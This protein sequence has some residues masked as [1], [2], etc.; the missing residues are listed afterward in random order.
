MKVEKFNPDWVSPKKPEFVVWIFLAVAK[1]KPTQSCIPVEVGLRG[2]PVH[3][4]PC[5]G[6]VQVDPVNLN[7]S[8]IEFVHSGN[9]LRDHKGSHGFEVLGAQHIVKCDACQMLGQC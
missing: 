4:I 2:E 7:I 3:V 6:N 9:I 8:A 1:R 5:C